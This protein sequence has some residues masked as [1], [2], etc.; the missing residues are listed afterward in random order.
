MIT[1][2]QEVHPAVGDQVNKAVFLS[3]SARP[4]S[5][6]HVLQRLWFAYSNE[7][8]AHY[9]FNKVKR[10][11]RNPSILVQPKAKILDELRLKHSKALRLE[12]TLALTLFSQA[13]LP[14]VELLWT[15]PSASLTLHD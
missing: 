15:L 10:P 11:E 4:N 8:V 7:R 2:L 1:R 3:Q 13:Q 12:Q 6:Q 5:P 14:C 9:S